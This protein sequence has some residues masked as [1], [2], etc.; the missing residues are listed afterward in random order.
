MDSVGIENKIFQL[1]NKQ[2]QFSK[3]SV[4]IISEKKTKTKN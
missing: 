1:L 3:E 4:T 2:E